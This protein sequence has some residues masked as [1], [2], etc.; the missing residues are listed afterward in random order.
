MRYQSLLTA[1]ILLAAGPLSARAHAL[2]DHA[3]PKVGS[4]VKKAPKIVKLWF[5]EALE[6]ARS[7]LQV[8]DHTDKQVDKKDAHLDKENP[9][10]FEVSLPALPPGEYKVVWRAVATDGHVTNGHFTFRILKE[11]H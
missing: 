10:L 2:L 7:R 6:P 9:C 5:T 4:E 11:G 1:L 8:F 3:E